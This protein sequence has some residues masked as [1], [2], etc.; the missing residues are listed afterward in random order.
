MKIKSIILNNFRAINQEKFDFSDN[1]NIIYGKNGQGKTSIIESIYFI[2]TGKSF[3]TKKI[4][5]QIKH[6]EKKASVFA[7]TK[8]NNFSIELLKDKKN[9][10]IDKNKC[11]Y[12][13]YIGKIL[14]VSFS[15]EDINL[16]S[17]TPEIRR[18]FF[19]YEISQT[20]KIYLKKIMEFQ[21]VLK[22]RN[23]F[24]KEGD[25]KSPIFDIYNKK[26]VELSIDIYDMRKKY[27]EKLSNILCEKYKELF[28]DE[29]EVS[30][31][32]EAFYNF[33]KE[34]K[35]EMIKEYQEYISKK[36]D[37]ELQFTYTLYGPQKDEYVFYLN[38]QRVKSYA[39][40]GEKKSIIF[41]LK[42]AQ[43]EYIVFKTNNNPIFLL[44]DI[45][46]YFD[47]NR[48]KK[49]LEY[50]LKRDIQCF[51]TSTEILD[52]EG[53]NFEIFNGEDVL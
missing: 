46:A 16:I 1:I 44:D 8:E 53:K 29:K 12:S 14:A 18:R 51:F 3:R 34:T 26:F 11:S 41:S 49:V 40:Q 36:I 48:K 28:G 52:I 24:L 19:N 47:E 5:E 35:E 25:I 50:F 15:P 42:I 6:T 7:K 31:K 43:I 10:Y 37:K 30:I 33:S 20:D 2:A 9:L 38:N 39:S 27:I 45:T 22:I 17:D 13:E 32:Y 21:K 4:F 23:K